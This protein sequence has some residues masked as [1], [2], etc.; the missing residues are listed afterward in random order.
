MSG[1]AAAPGSAVIDALAGQPA[2]ELLLALAERRED[3]ALVGGAVRDLL[4]GRRPR[5]LDVVVA[6]DS[7]GLAAELARQLP[8]G[9]A[10]VHERFGTAA[11]TSAR[12]TVDIA[13]RR[14]ETYFRPGALPD[15]RP[16]DTAE[17]LAR[18]DF[19]VN[20]MA[21]PLGGARR[22]QLDAVP[23]ALED[24]EHGRLRVLHDGSFRDDPTRLLRL[25]RYA[26]RLGYDI[27]PHTSRLAREAIDG[28]ALATV[29]GG[30]LA[31]ELCLASG[32]E[33]PLAAFAALAELGVPA[34]LGLPAR[35]DS[36]L[37]E[38]AAQLAPV[39]ARRLIPAAVMLRGGERAGAAGLLDGFELHAETRDRLLSAAF[40]ADELAA[41]MQ[42]AGR[43]S[44]LHALLS[45]R[46]IETVALAGAI[47]P[48]GARQPARDWIERLRH[49]QLEIDGADLLRAGVPQGPEIGRRLRRALDAKLDG[50]LDGA[51]REAELRVA[52][53]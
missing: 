9:E 10:T 52:L 31:T 21:V 49:V 46:P 28:G 14:A 18:R 32:E 27:E 7:A 48:G 39:Q 47:G 19:T 5:E 23:Y 44:A 36:E 50:E 24:L 53:A 34:G 30:R 3:L 38:R 45:A 29:S 6:G 17:D 11:V 1:A 37:A 43:P 33:R 8:Q 41:A 40:E 16:G 51:G 12:G 42:A 4:S 26:A 35:Y 22:G 15:V 2:G 13:E 20:A 25:A